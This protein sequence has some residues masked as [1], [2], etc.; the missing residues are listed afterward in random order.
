LSAATSSLG[1]LLKGVYWL[2]VLLVVSYLL[3]RYRREVARA[4]QEFVG[5]LRDLWDRLLGRAAGPRVAPAETAVVTE[6]PPRPFSSYIDPFASGVVGRYSPEQL[7]K[8][9]F[10]AFEAWSR[11]RGCARV[12]EQTPQEF[13]QAV[14]RHQ[15]GI[16][17]EAARL[18]E[19]YNH[20]AYGAGRLPPSVS[21]Q[22][23]GIWQQ[24][25]SGGARR[26]ESARAE[27]DSRERT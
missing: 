3:W 20:S 25:R 10:E 26:V 7:I 2:L 5:A 14:A 16:A 18:A 24:M 1:A 19:L 15:R 17:R 9:S 12:P 13:A 22:L 21:S 8:Y 11:E 6:P 4:V 23:A 27:M